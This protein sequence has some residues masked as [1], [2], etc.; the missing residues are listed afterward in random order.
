MRF[1][2]TPPYGVDYPY[3]LVNPRTRWILEKTE[4]E[5]A[6]LDSGVLIFHDPE[7]KEYPKSFKDNWKRDAVALT[8]TYGS[9]RV[10]CTI[11]DYPDDYNPGQFGDNVKKTLENIEEFIVV[12]NV[13]WVISL[14][15]RFLNIFT[16][17]EA[18]QGVHDLVGDYP[19][20]AVGTICKTNKLKFIEKSCRIA[21]A[22]F[23]DSY[24][25]AFGLT[26][27]ALPKVHRQLDSFDSM[28]W[29]FPRTPG[30]PS[31]IT[32]DDRVQY[33]NEYL[34]RIKEIEESSPY[35][36]R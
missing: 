30:R 8:D 11:P 24:I 16:F 20:V 35:A 36:H 18:I 5:H 28:A 9:D 23:P 2:T 33:F 3:L 32:Q 22:H 31:A 14:Q 34:A 6:I 12:D 15:S 27:R 25:H 1:Y 21:R 26:L 4:F 29:T 17:T 13:N 19:R 10:W 7:V